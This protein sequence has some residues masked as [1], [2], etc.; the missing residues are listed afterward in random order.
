MLSMETESRPT[1]DE[2]FGLAGAEELAKAWT[3]AHRDAARLAYTAGLR[4]LADLLD[5]APGVPLPFDGSTS[6]IQWALFDRDPADDLAAITRALPD[7]VK[8]YSARF[9][10][11]DAD[12]AGL[13]VQAFAIR[14]L[15]QPG[16]VDAVTAC[17]ACGSTLPVSS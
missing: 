5:A 13:K 12:L 8:S 14:D 4:L 15:V 2:A 17:G 9:V 7:P 1:I 10:Y 6:P 16:P 11:F 3:D